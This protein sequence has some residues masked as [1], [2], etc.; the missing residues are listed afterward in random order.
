MVQ[1]TRGKGPSGRSQLGKVQSAASVSTAG[2]DVGAVTEKLGGIM[3]AIGSEY[4]QKAQ[5]ALSTAIYDN[6]MGSATKEFNAQYQ[7]RA[8]DR[9]D[10]NGNPNFG[11]LAEDTQA[12]GEAVLKSKSN[13]LLDPVARQQFTRDFNNTINS[14]VTRA[15]ASA[16][17]QELDYTIAQSNKG[18]RDF[19][20]NLPAVDITSLPRELARLDK[21]Q[22]SYLDNGTISYAQY[23]KTKAETSSTAYK[24]KITEMIQKNPEVLRDAL[25]RNDPSVIGMDS[26]GVSE[27]E[28]ISL[29]D[30]AAG[31]IHDRAVY[32]AKVS[33]TRA[34][35]TTEDQNNAYTL[36]DQRLAADD[37]GQA[38]IATM[39][40]DGT[41]NPFQEQKLSQK[42][43]YKEKKDA[44]KLEVDS[45]ITDS[46]ATGVPLV[47][48][49]TKMLDDNFKGRLPANS[50]PQ[51]AGGL[52]AEYPAALPSI[53]KPLS[54]MGQSEDLSKIAPYL[55]QYDYLSKKNPA[56]LVGIS[57]KSALVFSTALDLKEH[58]PELPVEEVI[59]RAQHDILD[60]DK[61][62]YAERESTLNNDENFTDE[63]HI[64]STANRIFSKSGL[65]NYNLAPGITNALTKSLRRNYIAAGSKD[66][67]MSATKAEFAV[68]YGPTRLLMGDPDS[69]LG[70]SVN[71]NNSISLF[72]QPTIMAYAP[73]HIYKNTDFAIIQQDYEQVKSEGVLPEGVG[74][75]KIYFKYDTGTTAK[76]G[77]LSYAMEYVDKDGLPQPLKKPN[78][79]I[80]RWVTSRKGFDD[81]IKSNLVMA[82]EKLKVQQAADRIKAGDTAELMG[83]R[84]QAEANTPRGFHTG[85]PD[86]N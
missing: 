51:Q 42:L 43:Y 15:S 61:D 7:E 2:R 27:F 19:V 57:K 48:V 76:D 85:Q 79:D 49:T 81:I 28:R 52:A 77:E 40:N 86:I 50:T 32:D 53:V 46:I 56:S 54:Y 31:A 47:G 3:G 72:E 5:G 74:K 84:Y 23:E 26:F 22:I 10:K 21:V 63:D 70:V 44:A 41:V 55:E 82:N 14:S 11:K 35:K 29:S 60:V 80:L 69:F 45:I 24:F 39:G 78:G 1:I 6:A 36:A 16:R 83:L 68:A 18:V 59:K 8:A 67:A 66:S 34:K 75:E 4:M 37:L 73:E 25:D 30:V 65:F 62:V 9:L 13:M 20:G 71:S 58:N 33:K 17:T 12:I 38:E 64:K